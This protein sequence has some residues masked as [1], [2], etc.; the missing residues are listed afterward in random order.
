MSAD[1]YSPEEF[2]DAF[3]RR[4]YGK[5]KQAVQWLSENGV[6]IAT[7]DDFM[8]C[9]HDIQYRQIRSHNRSHISLC[10]DGQNPVSA[11]N[12]PNSCGR[13]FASLMAEENRE[14][15]RLNAW[16]KR[17]HKDK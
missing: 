12:V 1:T 5:K 14:M 6:S 3:W 9:Y 16:I 4:G 13:S 2:A 7:E 10:S 11:G 8:R 15:D 17:R